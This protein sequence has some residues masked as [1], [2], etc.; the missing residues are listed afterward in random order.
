MG[1]V[2]V[3]GGAR[4]GKSDLAVRLGVEAGRDVTFIATATAGD[5]EM[6]ERIAR[7]RESRPRGW[8]T[9]E[10][11]VQVCEAVTGSPAG[12]FVI[13]DCLTLWVANL[14]GAGRGA[15]E[16]RAMA[17]EASR[18]MAGRDG[19]VVTNEVGLGIV[20]A[21]AAAREF[22]DVLGGVNTIFAGASD[23]TLLMVAGQALELKRA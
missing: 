13:V 8:T 23:R 7:H 4:S 3:L 12:D 10:A 17:E 22:R 14:L 19:V 15:D 20:P 6:A 21:N 5:D 2:L 18:A 16:V 1:Y 9:L 11:P